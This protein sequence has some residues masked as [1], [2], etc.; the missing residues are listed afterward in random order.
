MWHEIFKKKKKNKKIAFR[1]FQTLQLPSILLKY[2]LFQENC[3][4]T[5]LNLHFSLD[6]VSF[7]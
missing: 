4:F 3:Y 2:L 1:G 7:Q 6:Y 5:S